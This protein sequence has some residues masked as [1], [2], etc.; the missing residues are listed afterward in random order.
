[1]DYNLFYTTDPNAPMVKVIEFSGAY[2]MTNGNLSAET[3]WDTNS[4]I[5]QN[6]QFVAANNYHLLSGSP[7]KAAGIYVGSV[8][9]DRDGNNGRI[10]LRSR[11]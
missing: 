6:P 7:A 4:P 11:V 2:Q 1:M 8:N 3:G 10:H 5:P 9:K